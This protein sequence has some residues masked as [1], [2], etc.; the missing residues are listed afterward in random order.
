MSG[1]GQASGPFR[2]VETQRLDAFV[3]AA[4]AFA[5][6][7]LIIAGG[8]PLRSLDDLL[9]ALA[10]IPAFAAGFALLM[11]FWVAHRTWSSLSP[12]RGSWATL[13]SLMVVFSVLVFVFPLRLLV[14]T[15]THFLSA[16]A[17]PG[18]GLVSTLAELRWTYVI[19]GVGFAILSVQYALLFRQA[20]RALDPTDS[21]RR[22]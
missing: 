5:V 20:R 13:L 16:G 19:Y 9:R 22:V 12:E 18:R 2:T 11:L 3:D 21:V 4:F 6:S 14:E 8:E 17:L 7:L 1:T 10:R 15:A